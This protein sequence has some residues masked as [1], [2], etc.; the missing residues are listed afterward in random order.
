[1]RAQNLSPKRPDASFLK[2]LS[3]DIKRNTA[4][5]RKLRLGAYSVAAG[6]ALMSE[7][8]GLN[9]S[10]YVSE[11]V[12][13]I[14]EAPLKMSDL[15][16]AV[17]LVSALHQRYAEFASALVPALV[18][19]FAV[20]KTPEVEADKLAR[21]TRKRVTARL[22]VELYEAGIYTETAPLTAVLA[23]L[24]AALQG[25]LR[26]KTQESFAHLPLITSF[27][28]AA[29]DLL[30]L[31]RPPEAPPPDAADAASLP[32]DVQKQ[33]IGVA[34]SAFE[35]V[36]RALLSEHRAMRGK[37]RENQKMLETRGELTEAASAAYD[38]IR[39]IHEKLQV[40]MSY[41]EWENNLNF[42]SLSLSFFLFFFLPAWCCRI[43]RIIEQAAS[44]TSRRPTDHAHCSGCG[45]CSASECGGGGRERRVGR[46]GHEGLL[47]EPA[48]PPRARP[49]GAP[50]RRLPQRGQCRRR[51]WRREEGEEQR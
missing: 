44:C 4:F 24:S 13:A 43:S 47:R 18:K 45:R 35:S 28:R 5:I 51:G 34:E 41:I 21:L 14:A 8:N 50:R 49:C 20:V 40:C 3:S 11:A 15:H 48:R 17:R 36:C 42:F 39:K 32:A 7:F 6:D 26:D 27:L 12:A 37:E 31:A 46:R 29:G 9:L 38:K 19:H 22:L 2:T 23:D 25:E 1:M 10:R 16:L 33:M 30:G